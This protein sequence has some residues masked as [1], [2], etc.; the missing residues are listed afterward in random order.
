[1]IKNRTG[2]ANHAGMANRAGAPR[3]SRREFVVYGIGMIGL[4]ASLPWPDLA[5]A[6]MSLLD[7]EME[8]FA[9]GKPLI[10]ESIL[11]DLPDLA[12]NGNTVPLSLSVESPMTADS[13]VARVLLLAESNPQ[14]RIAEFSFTPECGR[15][16][17]E[18]RIRLIQSQ[19]VTALAKMNDGAVY[20]ARKLVKVTIGG[21]G[22]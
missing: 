4:P 5:Y 18:T 9:A 2:M 8:A 15:C 1:M 6:G 21:C 14:P 3:F 19:H 10:E 13:F 20:A 17:V 16:G 22:G 11:L 12:E 7:D